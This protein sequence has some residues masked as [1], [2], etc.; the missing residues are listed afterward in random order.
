MTPIEANNC[1]K[2]LL[3]RKMKTATENLNLSLHRGV[4]R[5]QV[6]YM[7][8]RFR[9]LLRFGNEDSLYSILFNSGSVEGQNDKI[10]DT[11]IAIIFSR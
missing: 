10:K 3:V 6:Q 4:C 7:V 5:N 2:Y 8:T 1:I 9:S 11:E